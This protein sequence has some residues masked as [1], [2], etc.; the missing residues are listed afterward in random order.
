V[1]DTEKTNEEGRKPRRNPTV[2]YGIVAA[3]L[4]VI[5]VVAAYFLVTQGLPALRGGEEPTAT[6]EGEATPSP[7]PTFTPAPTLP[8]T[9]TPPPAPSPTLGV[10]AMRDTDTPIFELKSAGGRPGT[11]WTGF[12]GQVLDAQGEPL[13]GVPL[14]IWYADPEGRPAELLN[15]PDSPIVSSAADGSYE[16]RLADAPF[17]GLWSIQVLTDDGGP[18]SKL[19]TFET[20]D[21][22]AAGF[23]QIQVIWQALP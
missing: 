3:L 7:V 6:A 1:S 21:D 16:M 23:Q 2:V 10:P 13:A 22:P 9:D 12:F 17:G 15:S 20:S 18:A 5:I 8:P 19:F 11:E 14:I 4:V